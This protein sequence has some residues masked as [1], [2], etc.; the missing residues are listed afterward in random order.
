MKYIHRILQHVTPPFLML[1]S[2]IV[3]IVVILLAL[4]P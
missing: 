4:N 3:T 1:M 2:G